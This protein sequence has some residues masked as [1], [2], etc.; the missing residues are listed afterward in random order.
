MVWA[1]L[2]CNSLYNISSDYEQYTCHLDITMILSV[3]SQHPIRTHHPLILST[4]LLSLAQ[5]NPSHALAS[6]LELSFV[7]GDSNC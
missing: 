7:S 1:K 4:L 6:S 3:A 2:L 5:V